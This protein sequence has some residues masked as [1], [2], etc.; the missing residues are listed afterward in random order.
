[1]A[2]KGMAALAPG[3]GV[4]MDS[5][6]IA[7]V[8]DGHP[9]GAEFEPLFEAAEVGQIRLFVTPITLAEVV[10]GPLG[11]GR[12]A[13]AEQ[14]R[15]ALTSGPGFTFTPLGDDTAF[16]AARF[17]RRYKLK[18][19]D[20]FQLAACVLSGCQALATH[21]RDFRHVSEVKVLDIG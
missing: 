7:Y 1:M 3:A 5:P 14:Y 13:Q 8:L 2:L 10:A 19:P 15:L 11:R 4:L 9:L 20:A 16:L 21:D 6:P 18:L 17:R 12:E